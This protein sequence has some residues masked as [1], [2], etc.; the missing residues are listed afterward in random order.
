MALMATHGEIRPMPTG[1]I[2]ADTLAEPA[3]VYKWLDWLEPRLAFPVYRVSQGE[4]L[5]LDALLIRKRKDGEG[6]WVPS[7]IPHYTI[8]G[9]G[10]NGHGPRQCTQ[11]FKIAPLLRE[12]R[13]LL[14]QHGAR[15]ATSWIG[16][17]LEE[18]YRMK[19]SRVSYCTNIW[20]LIERGFRRDDCLRWMKRNGY[21]E[22]P[23]S[24]CVFCPY[25]SDQ[26]WRRLKDEE[27]L[28]FQKAVDFERAYGLAK[29][30]TVGMRPFLHASRVPLAE[31]DFST[32]LERGQLSLWAN[33]CEG[34]CG[35]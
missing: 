28:E 32:D 2:F 24:A 26:E 21:P 8:N 31:V 12:I 15:E 11:D 3:S 18:V 19:P 23:R 1:A 16:L 9:D 35:V 17:S 14:R 27:P 34:M 7:A 5:A 13:R 20:P 10:S 30:Q 25:H 6:S 4:G 29:M 33:E 22:P